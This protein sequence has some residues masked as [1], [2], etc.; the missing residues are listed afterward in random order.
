MLLKTFCWTTNLAITPKFN[1]IA[2]YLIFSDTIMDEFLPNEA[3]GT[4][5]AQPVQSQNE[6]VT[7][8]PADL[9]T[10]GLEGNSFFCKVTCNFIRNV[11]LYILKSCFFRFLYSESSANSTVHGKF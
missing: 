3:S 9:E 1:Q 10:Y 7:L 4:S 8:Q 2:I 11:F 6:T 5:L